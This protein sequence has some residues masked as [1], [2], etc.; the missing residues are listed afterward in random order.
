[1]E[2]A[3]K[4][5]DSD[6]E[7]GGDR[8]GYGVP[9]YA[10]S[11]YG[12]GQNET[13]VQKT[14]QDYLLILRERIWYVVLAFLAVFASSIVFTYS[15][16]PL[17]QS[18]ATVQIF[19]KE[20]MV[21]RVQQV[22]DTDINTTEDLNTQIDI[23]KSDTIIDRVAGRLTGDNLH[24]FLAPYERVGKT[25]PSVERILSANREIVPERLSLI[26][27]IQYRHP[28]REI[29]ALVANL[30]ADEYIAYNAHAQVDES[31]KAVEELQQRADSQRKKVDEIA[32]ALQTYRERNHMVSL[33][34][35][36]D[37]VTETLKD[38]NAHVTQNAAALQDAET[39]WKQVLQIESTNGNF[40]DLPFIANVPLIGQLEQQ[41]ANEKI[42]VAQLSQRYRPKHP[43]MIAAM[44]SLNS[45]ESQLQQAIKTAMAQIESSYQT[46]LQNYQQA[47]AALA[48]QE[49]DSLKLAH[50]A[51]EYSNMAR[52]YDVNEKLLEQI[53]ERMHETSVSGTI[54][55]QNG[56][57]VD[58]ARPARSSISPKYK[59]NIGLGAV[60]GLFIGVSLAF[61][62][63]FL[64]DRV[65]SAFDIEV[66]IG[67][68][69]LGIVPKID[70]LGEAEE[71]ENALIKSPDR[72]AAEAFATLYSAL[73]LKDDSK[74]AQC[75]LVTSTLAGEGKSFITTRLASTY[76]AHGTRTVVIDC[77]LRRP[78]VHRVF[79]LE[80]LKGVIDVI[81]GEATLDD[82]IFKNVRPNMDVITTGGRAKNPTQTLNSKAFALMLSELRKRY[83]R[84]FIDTPPIAIVS[85]ALIVLPHVDGSLYAIYFNKARRKAAQHC[86]QRLL[87]SNIPNFGAILNGLAG[88]M[89]SY[90]YN[91]YDDKS[92]KAYYVDY[93]QKDL[94]G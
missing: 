10:Y 27:D 77:D 94:K 12:Y 55:S 24:R 70:K 32:N 11:A 25:V 51:V 61:F 53:L 87:E 59:L 81:S 69:L 84:I 76:S 34:Q 90:Y 14:L 20:A 92:Y 9:G 91:R 4:Q 82:V 93:D 30:F 67:L 28:D 42:V 40:L 39:K 48:V 21:M 44:N 3:R 36:Q 68:R 46:S 6:S 29:A 88:G 8:A 85:D 64:D 60:G 78:A 31:I 74:N 45:G 62:V 35:R 66:V 15:Q 2:P 75:L 63:A 58:R 38:L 47:R 49:A 54:E 83:D 65:K 89:G 71:M 13:V 57:I 37:I 23:L 22:M 50:Y 56:R 72:A 79:H 1:M 52:D 18:V 7:Y 86:A 73:Q 43:T 19:R 41:V 5:R 26:L 80:N 16:I 33:D 17:F